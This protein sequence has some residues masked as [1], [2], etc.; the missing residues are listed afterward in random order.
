VRRYRPP[1]N[2]IKAVH[3]HKTFKAIGLT[4]WPSLLGK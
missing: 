2:S 3:G 1:L 4:V